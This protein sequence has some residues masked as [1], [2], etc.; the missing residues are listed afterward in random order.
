MGTKVTPHICSRT[1]VRTWASWH[2][3]LQSFPH[4]LP[5]FLPQCAPRSTPQRRPGS[6]CLQGAQVAPPP[7]D[8]QRWK[9]WG[10]ICPKRD[11]C[12]SGPSSQKAIIWAGDDSR[13]WIID[14]SSPSS[15]LAPSSVIYLPIYLRGPFFSPMNYVCKAVKCYVFARPI[16]FKSPAMPAPDSSELPPVC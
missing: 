9:I 15:A 13:V 6:Y 3:I 8:T 2:L 11:R 10:Q 7:R 12:L 14:F 1:G 16:I 4:T 5:C